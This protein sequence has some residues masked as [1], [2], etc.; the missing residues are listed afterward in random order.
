[1]IVKYNGRG[2]REE[3]ISKKG[4][5]SRRYKQMD[6]ERTRSYGCLFIR[7]EDVTRSIRREDTI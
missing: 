6:K 5:I 1:M 2:Y 3:E 4:Y 7:R